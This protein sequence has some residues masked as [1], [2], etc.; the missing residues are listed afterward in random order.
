MLNKLLVETLTNAGY[1]VISTEDGFEAWTLIQTCET[2]EELSRK[3]ECLITDI[4]MPAMDGITLSKQIKDSRV[5]RGLPIIVFSS[6]VNEALRR[7]VQSLD[8]NCMV[9]KPEIGKLV[10]AVDN[11]ILYKENEEEAHKGFII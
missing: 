10:A 3:F 9:S 4:E 5:Y 8:I 1:R 6:L 11:L 7:K 2:A